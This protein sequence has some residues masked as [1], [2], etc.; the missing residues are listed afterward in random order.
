[1]NMRWRYPWGVARGSI[2]ASHEDEHFTLPIPGRLVLDG[3]DTLKSATTLREFLARLWGY[4]IIGSRQAYRRCRH[5]ATIA[6][7]FLHNKQA[8]A[9]YNLEDCQLVWD[10]FVHTKL[11]EPWSSV[12]V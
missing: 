7:Q 4:C 3:I 11:I 1:M 6:E 9:A 10:I 5:R 2:G 12:R 8:L